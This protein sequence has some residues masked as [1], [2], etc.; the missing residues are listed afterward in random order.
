[1]LRRINFSW[2]L[3]VL[4]AVLAAFEF[5]LSQPL[6]AQSELTPK[7]E[8]TH[9]IVPFV[10]TPMKVAERMLEMARVTPSDVVYDLGSGDGRIVIM[11]AQKYGARAVGVELNGKLY[12]ESSA[13]IEELGLASKAKI[14][15]GDMFKAD[16]HPATVVTLYLLTSVNADIRPMLEKQLRP[17]TRVVSHDFQ[18][19][20][21]TPQKTEEISDQNGSVHTV[22]LYIKQGG[23][24]E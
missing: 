3:A 4:L 6:R 15:L 14:L 13:R 20:A 9:D 21:W 7:Y 23:R 24:S 18:M 2:R 17:G 12:K 16:I 19:T 10:P 22:Y 11:A 5:P 8:A 1:M